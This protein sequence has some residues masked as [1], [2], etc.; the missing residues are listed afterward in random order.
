MNS[1]VIRKIVL[2]VLSLCLATGVGVWWHLLGTICDEPTT[3]L[4]L[5][6]HTVPYNCHGKTVFITANQQ[7][8]LDWCIPA[9]LVLALLANLVKKRWPA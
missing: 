8:V 2:A 6:G 1:Q 3:A 7:A 4:S 9:M 5:S